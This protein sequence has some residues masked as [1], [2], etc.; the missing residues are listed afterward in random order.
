[1]K[2]GIERPIG[3]H[4]E[5]L[6]LHEAPGGAPRRV[7][8]VAPSVVEVGEPF[9][10]AV[11]VLDRHGLPCTRGTGQVKLKRGPLLPC[12]QRVA[13]ESGEVAA[14]RL[15]AGL[16]GEEGLFRI[17]A[18]YEGKAVVSNPV[19]CVR[20]ARGRLWWG[21][22]H[23][24]TVLSDCHAD[25]CRMPD[26]ASVM[27]RDVYFLDWVTLA[28]H[29]SNGRG[30]RGKWRALRLTEARYTEPGRFVM[31][32]GY[33][34]SLKG[35][36]GG[37]NNIYFLGDLAL[38]V[39][40]HDGGNVRTLCE[41]LEGTRFFTVPHHTSR[42]GKHGAIPE[43]IY[44]GPERMP[45]VE[46]HSKW[47]TSEH[48]GNSTPLHKIA[49]G[50]VYVQDLLRQG[51]HLGFVGGTDTHT[52]LTFARGIEPGH[53]DRPPGITAVAASRLSQRSIFENILR[54]NCY[55]ASGQRIFLEVTVAGKPMG[56][57]VVCSP[58]SAPAGRTIRVLCGAE[59]A[60]AAVEIVRNGE[61]IHTHHPDSW[62]AEFSFTDTEP[63]DAC[64]I[65]ATR[66]KTNFVYYYVRVTTPSMA[67]AWSSPVRFVL[68]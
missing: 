18:E 33:E 49:D 3:P 13:F 66:M 1:M 20:K 64:A 8:L 5:D 40:E 56:R 6:I 51:Y 45:V 15:A 10:I 29:V 16:C 46:I 34:A 9:D 59:E 47:G 4:A 57:E 26:V 19:G 12:T 31:L 36:C 65:T 48:R 55:A 22:P 38:Y 60:I 30:S 54:R 24:H 27:A 43:S 41:K 17:E 2:R 25:R 28:D 11:S 52:S 63:L 44:P 42:T 62:K 32:P 23:I 58:G 35:G 50:P 53:I 39:D 21:D 68:E 7:M 37:D 14:R 67:K 61:V